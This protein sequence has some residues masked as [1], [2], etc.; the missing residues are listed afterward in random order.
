MGNFLDSY[1]GFVDMTQNIDN[2]MPDVYK[3]GEKYDNYRQKVT[4]YRKTMSD[5][6]EAMRHRTRQPFYAPDG[7][8]SDDDT[9]NKRRRTRNRYE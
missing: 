3:Q 9:R 5:I 4:S 2:S 6:D 8:T 7:Y 1:S